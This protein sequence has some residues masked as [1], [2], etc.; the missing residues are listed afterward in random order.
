MIGSE[1]HLGRSRSNLALE[2]DKNGEKQMIQAS[3]VPK[4]GL[5][6]Q[7]ARKAVLEAYGWKLVMVPFMLAWKERNPGAKVIP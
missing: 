4:Y 6:G 3:S 7:A 5:L 1:T 2:A